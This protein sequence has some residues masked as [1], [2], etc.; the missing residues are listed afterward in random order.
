[1]NWKREFRRIA[2]ASAIFTAIVCA[3]LFVLLTLYKH[4]DA[5]SYLQKKKSVPIVPAAGR[6]DFYESE[7]P[8]E[9]ELKELENGFW[10]NLSA[11]GLG[12]LC[13]LAGLSGGIIGFVVVWLIYKFLEWLVLGFCDNNRLPPEKT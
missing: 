6:V 8:T 4:N 2:F 3:G 5:E 1:M 10:V 7:R 12:G 9:T 13:V 11:K